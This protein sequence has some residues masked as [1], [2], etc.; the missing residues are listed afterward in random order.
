MVL[1]HAALLHTLPFVV[2]ALVVVLL[3]AAIVW[4]D[5]RQGREER[6]EP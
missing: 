5:R 2:P 3:G 1:A 6:E 4:R